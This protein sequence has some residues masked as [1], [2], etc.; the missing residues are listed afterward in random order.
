MLPIRRK[1]YSIGGIQAVHSSD[2]I[3][4]GA[5]VS[6]PALGIGPSWFASLR[7]MP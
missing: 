3:L 5:T 2:P 1:G 4:Q 6:Q 7:P